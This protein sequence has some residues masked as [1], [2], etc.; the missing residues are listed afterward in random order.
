MSSFKI[1]GNIVD[2]CQQTIFPGTVSVEE[3]YITAIARESGKDYEEF[4]LPGFIDAHVHIESSMLVPTEF[5]RLAT[6]HG[7]VAAVSDPHE[8]ANVLGLSGV[9]F[10]VD[11]AAQTPF[12][13]AFGAP[14]CVPATSFETAG[15]KLTS[16]DIR[17]LF[18][19]KY[20]SYLSEMMNVQ[21]Y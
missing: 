18:E 7:T 11:N 13:I 3:G 4:I 15:A 6:V 16:K 1:S 5:A 9:R 19:Q 21:G 14:A 8:I 2:V 17:L 12:K 10:M 20:V